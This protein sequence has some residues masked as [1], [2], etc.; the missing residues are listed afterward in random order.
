[1]PNRMH[2]RDRLNELAMK[3]GPDE[4]WEWPM[5]RPIGYG[6]AKV[7]GR[8]I[9]AHRASYEHFVGPIEMGLHIDHLC[10]NTVCVNPRHLEPVTCREN[11]LRGIGPSALAFKKT[12]CKEGHPFSTD[13]TYIIM[14]PNGRTERVCIECERRKKGRKYRRGHYR[15]FRPSESH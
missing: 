14:R 4:C 2:F 10:R 7:N 15:N 12:H 1:M 3:Y 6:Y 9:P 11:V 8:E 13:N 5:R